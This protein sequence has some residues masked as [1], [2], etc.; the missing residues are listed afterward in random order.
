MNIRKI[1]LTLLDEYE[2][3]G[4]YVN[5]SLTSHLCDG[6]SSEER[7]S[8]TALLY[9]TVENKLRYDYYIKALA[10]R[11]DEKLD[12]TTLNI[13]RL[14]ACQ[15]IDMKKIPDY[16]AVS[17]TVKL[18]RGP[19]ERAFINGVLRAIA[20]RKDNLPMPSEE[21]NYKRHLSVKYSFP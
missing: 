14:G 21:K 12:I 6:L 20:R 8:L 11:G 19:G 1:A 17:E 4:K 2:A 7:G 18:G 9:T 16:A 13:L 3:S 5:L 15:I 10:A